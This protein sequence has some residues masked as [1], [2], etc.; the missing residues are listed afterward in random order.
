VAFS[1]RIRYAG[2]ISACALAIAA[3]QAP[4]GGLLVFTRP[5]IVAATASTSSPADRTLFEDQSYRF[6]VRDRRQVV[7]YSKERHASVVVLRV[8][9]EHGRFGHAPPTVQLGWE[10]GGLINEEFA[11]LPLNGNRVPDRAVE[12]PSQYAYRVEYGTALNR[13]DAITSFWLR[14]LDLDAAF[15]GEREAIVLPPR[16]STIVDAITD[17]ILFTTVRTNAR[18]SLWWSVD[19]A[20][21][22]TLID[23][24]AARR[25]PAVAKQRSTRVDLSIG[26]AHLDGVGVEVSNVGLK[27]RHAVGGVLGAV[28][29]E[30]FGVRVDYDRRTMELFEPGAVTP[31]AGAIPVAADWRENVPVARVP[32][33]LSDGRTI[34]PRLVIDSSEPRPLVLYRSFVAAERVDPTARAASLQ[35]GAHALT[36]LPIAVSDRQSEHGVRWDGAIGSGLLRRFRVTFDRF[37][38]RLLLEPG[39]LLSVPY[40]YDAS[41]L[42]I[43]ANGREFGIGDLVPGYASSAGFRVGDIIVAMDGRRVAGSTLADVRRGLKSDG[44]DHALTIERFGAIE[45]VTYRARPR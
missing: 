7:V 12:I 37:R 39:T 27:Q 41:G 10:D 34:R 29:F 45:T 36:D 26:G 15:R 22:R 20:S 42:R 28:L 38:S 1:S 16:N 18:E 23:T 13:E 32:V 35:L 5:T 4:A 24:A 43:V 14:K 9:T 6:A 44:R 40:D 33:A 2:H 3:A 11:T 21:A 31:G 8:S 17:P 30:R 25:D 19:T